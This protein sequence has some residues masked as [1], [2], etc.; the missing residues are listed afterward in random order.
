MSYL[1]DD[2]IDLLKQWNRHINLVQS[3]T[4]DDVKTRHIADSLQ[5]VP[6]LQQNG[7]IFDIGSGAGFPGI[8][9]AIAG[10]NNVVLIEKDLKKSVFL[11]EVR[12]KLNLDCQIY[13]C[14]VY[15]LDTG[16]YKK[17]FFAISRAFGS[18]DILINIMRKLSIYDGIFHRGK[19]WQSELS[20]ISNIHHEVIPSSLT[21]D[22]ILLKIQLV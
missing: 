12:R 5:L 2:Y 17:P 20:A 16:K 22:S 14:D 18:L 8:I 4:V 19:T 13:A 10:F 6:Y 7:T 15:K 3:D 11:K 1:F 9:L 21:T